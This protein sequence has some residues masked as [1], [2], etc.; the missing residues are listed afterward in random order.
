MH[1]DNRVKLLKRAAEC[2]ELAATALTDDGRRVLL[3]LADQYEQAAGAD[4][5]SKPLG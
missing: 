2:R 3:E 4:P 5:A 1:G